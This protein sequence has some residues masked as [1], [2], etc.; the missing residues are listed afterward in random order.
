VDE[1]KEAVPPEPDPDLVK[2]YGKPPG[3]WEY[4]LIAVAAVS[5]TAALALRMFA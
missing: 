2:W 4:I 3:K 5:I 1:N